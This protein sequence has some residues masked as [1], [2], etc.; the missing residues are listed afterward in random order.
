MSI[1]FVSF[2]CLGFTLKTF[3]GSWCYNQGLRGKYK[4]S[5][6]LKLEVNKL[7][8]HLSPYM[9]FYEGEILLGYGFVSLDL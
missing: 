9:C 2:Y 1:H 8:R 5:S 7:M 3:S 4:W 6:I